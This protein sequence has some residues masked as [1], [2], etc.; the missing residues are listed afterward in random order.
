MMMPVSSRPQGGCFPRRELAENVVGLIKQNKL[1]SH[2][3]KKTDGP[4]RLDN[5]QIFIATGVEMLRKPRGK[6]CLDML[7]N[8]LVAG[9]N[10]WI[11]ENIGLLVP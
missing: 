11:M 3:Q 5:M 8:K 9:Q 2:G 4:T 10:S 1:L 6:G 7:N